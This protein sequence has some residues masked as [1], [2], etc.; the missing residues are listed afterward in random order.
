MLKLIILIFIIIP[1]VV[2]SQIIITEVCS[3][4]KSTLFDEN[5]NTPDWIELTN[6]S[7]ETI[8][9]EDFYLTNSDSRFKLPNLKLSTDS[10]ILFWK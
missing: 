6:I 3:S 1:N 7:D 5:L 10:S 4:N 9:L 2:F 8:S